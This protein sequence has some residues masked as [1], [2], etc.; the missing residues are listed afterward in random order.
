MHVHKLATRRHGS[1]CQTYA[2]AHRDQGSLTDIHVEYHATTGHAKRSSEALDFSTHSFRRCIE[3][4]HVDRPTCGRWNRGHTNPH[5][6][7]KILSGHIYRSVSSNIYVHTKV[8]VEWVKDRSSRTN[9]QV[10][11]IQVKK[12][13]DRCYW[14][15]YKYRRT[16]KYTHVLTLSSRLVM[17]RSRSKRRGQLSLPH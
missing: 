16:A 4:D 12:S 3:C 13:N 1:I 17:R 15:T 9:D 14:R 2:I 11:N 8:R 10:S 6:L 7:I 5:S